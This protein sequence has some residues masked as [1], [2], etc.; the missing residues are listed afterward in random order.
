M[1]KKKSVPIINKLKQKV[2]EG[3]PSKILYMLE[4]LHES[5][6]N[7]KAEVTATLDHLKE[8][9]DNFD[10][11]IK[12]LKQDLLKWVDSYVEDY[13]E[14]HQKEIKTERANALKQY[15]TL[16]TDIVNIGQLVLATQSSIDNSQTISSLIL[17]RIQKWFNENEI[18]D[19]DIKKHT[20]LL[21]EKELNKNEETDIAI[22]FGGY[23]GGNTGI[24]SPQPFIN[25]YK[26]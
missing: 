1:V 13:K 5:K 8:A 24:Y 26:I 21:L 10:D 18:E 25:K 23:Q 17:K 22:K 6:V 9:D 19:L 16:T 12:Q 3:P 20:A 4:S 15:D 2:P 14:N 11:K 7:Q